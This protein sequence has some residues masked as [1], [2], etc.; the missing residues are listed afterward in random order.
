MAVLTLEVPELSVYAVTTL[1][2][3]F[4]SCNHTFGMCAVNITMRQV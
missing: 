2:G 3:P 1:V 4:S